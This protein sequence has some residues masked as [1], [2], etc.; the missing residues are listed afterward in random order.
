MVL[1]KHRFDSRPKCFHFSCHH[2]RKKQRRPLM[3]DLFKGCP[4][5]S[6]FEI[7]KYKLTY[8]WEDVKR[9]PERANTLMAFMNTTLFEAG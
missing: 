3:I 1:F 2:I 5:I 6:L 9:Q 7:N 4:K 8:D